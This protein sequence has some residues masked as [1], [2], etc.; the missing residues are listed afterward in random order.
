MSA[1]VQGWVWDLDIPPQP[2]LILLWLANRAT[3]A[4]VCF[5]TK[6]ELGRRTGLS[7]RMVR[8]HLDLLARHHD[9]TG[10]P[11]EPVVSIIE[12]RIAGDRNTS[13][14]YV[15]R[16]PWADALIVRA[17]LDELKHVPDAALEGVGTTGCTQGGDH[18]LHPVGTTGCTEVGTTGCT[19][20]RSLKERHRNTPPNPPG[21]THEQQRGRVWSDHEARGPG[22]ASGGP[23]EQAEDPAESLVMAFYGGLGADAGSSPPPCVGGITPSHASS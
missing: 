3:D 11:C 13:N 20:N 2:K 7:E 19:Q 10:A 5:P 6:R 9:A 21:P 18:G 1:K 8:Y 12:R 16:V 23:R 15:L 4:G 17:E 14:V 22:D